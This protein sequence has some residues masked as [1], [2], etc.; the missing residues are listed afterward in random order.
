MKFEFLNIKD[1]EKA[2]GIVVF[3]LDKSLKL[4]QSLKKIDKD[5]LLTQFFQL[6]K[7]FKGEIGD[8]LMIPISKGKIKAITVVGV[9]EEKNIETLDFKN[10]GG[11][12]ANKA[13][14][15]H[16]N[17]ISI[18]TELNWKKLDSTSLALKIA[19]GI[20]LRNYSFNKY[21]IDKKD[22]H[23]LYLKNVYIYADAHTKAKE[24]FKS[25]EKSVEGTLYTRDLVSEPS[26]V[27][28]PETFMK[29]CLEFE[30]L[31][32]KVKVLDKKEMKKL[33]MNALLG[34]SQGSV[35]EPYTV[36][37]EWN[38]NTKKD[39]KNP[40]IFVG[41]GVTFDTGGIN[42]KPSGS[43]LSDMKYD[44]GGAGVV[45]GLMYSLALRKAKVN[46]VGAIGLAENMPSGSAQRPS[47]VIKSMSG[48]TIEV[49]NTDAEGRLLLA[50]VMWYVQ[51][52][53]KPKLMID[54]AT[55]T[56]AII[57][58]L[59]ENKYSGLFSNDDKLAEKL[60]KAGEDT[61]EQ[62]WRLPIGEFYDNQINS[63]IADVKNTHTGKGGGSITAAQF[64]KRFVKNKCPWAHIDIAGVTW[65][66]KGSDIS[67]RGATGYGVRLLNKF[68]RDNYEL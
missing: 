56:G 1:V 32:I 49:D 45:T 55:L 11:K 22:K 44:M 65:N 38:G 52:I 43:W 19:T 10:V 42:I 48:Q 37:M 6:N 66:K 8:V 33:G 14:Q 39:A 21:F 12:I 63:Q 30:K 17:T 61:G 40:L 57:A 68:I 60:L 25:C 24:C 28:Y 3:L 35:K 36:I 20:K 59:G 67:P 7:S 47:D 53:Y 62:L 2:N 23:Q 15:L 51:S 41:K 9:G 50:D 26:N 13:N 31:G 54:L 16:S 29:K 5:N 27:L 46:V 34:V 18:C 58:A 4:P 64:L